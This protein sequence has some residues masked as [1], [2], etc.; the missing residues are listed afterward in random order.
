HQQRYA[1][2]EAN[3]K[4]AWNGMVQ[5]QSTNWFGFNTESMLGAVLVAQGQYEEAEPLLVGSYE[6]MLK[7]TPQTGTFYQPTLFTAESEPGERILKLYQ[8]W[9]KPEKVREWRQKTRGAPNFSL[10]PWSKW[11]QP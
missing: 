7:L 4:Q 1:D 8:G 10:L 9:G 3:L 6:A 2:A 5:N 11:F